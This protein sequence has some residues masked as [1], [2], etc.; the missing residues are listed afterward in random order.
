[1]NVIMALSLLVPSCASE[2]VALP[3]AAPVHW[4]GTEAKVP[5]PIVPTQR[6]RALAEAYAAAI[7]S[8]S[9]A[10]LGAMLSDDVHFLFGERDARGRE[11]VVKSHQELFGAFDNRQLTISR[12]WLTDSTQLVNSQAFEWT[13]TGIQA[14]AWMGTAP[15]GKSVVIRGLTLLWTDDDGVISEIHVYL[16]EEAVKAELTAGQAPAPVALTAP[17][18]LEHA[19][20]KEEAANVAVARGVLQALED[21]KESA[22]VSSMSDDLDV[23]MPGTSETVHGK[24]G[25]R[26]YFKSTRKSIRQLD[27]IVQ[28]AWGVGSFVV[29]EYALAG[30]QTAS[31]RRPGGTA[32][33]A[34][35]PLQVHYVD[36]AELRSGMIARI[37]RYADRN[38]FGAS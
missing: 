11:R 13:M 37:W 5:S 20:T 33:G 25:A 29:V 14:R 1:A 34:L 15:T 7:T 30:L 23:V 9:F 4:Q 8:T 16:D 26:S 36:I 17:Q 2:T 19:G 31:S 24:S 6:E 27:T 22:F 28:N 32:D 35:H 10:K 21:D 18:V 12:V 3:P 38:P